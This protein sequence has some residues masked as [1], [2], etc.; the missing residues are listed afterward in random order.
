MAGSES[1]GSTMKYLALAL[2]LAACGGA[3]DD[4]TGDDAPGSDTVAPT[5]GT[6]ITITAPAESTRVIEWGAATDDVTAPALLQYKVVRG[7]D[8]VDLD[9]LELADAATTLQD[10]RSAT[11]TLE[12]DDLGVP[13]SFAVAVIVRDQTGNEALYAA[14]DVAVTDITPPD[15]TITAA[16]ADPTTDSTG[17]FEFSSDDPTATFQCSVDG[18]SFD[19]CASPFSTATLS[20]GPHTFAV[21]AV[22]A[23]SNA[24]P[25]PATA[26]WTFDPAFLSFPVGPTDVLETSEDGGSATFPLAL[27]AK[28]DSDVTVTLTTTD[29]TEGVV[30]T[31]AQLVFTPS[32][33]D[34]P[35]AVV[36]TGLADAD[37][38]DVTYQLQFTVESADVGYD[39]LQVTPIQLVNRD[40]STPPVVHF[41][42][43]VPSGTFFTNAS[44]VDI[45]GTASDA[46]GV[47]SVTWTNTVAAASGTATGTTTWSQ[48]AV[49]LV[50]GGN[51]IIATATDA[52][53]NQAIALVVVTRD[54]TPP[55][56]TITVPTTS[57]SITVDTPTIELGGNAADNV[58]VAS[59]TWKNLGTGATGTA[60]GTT[61]WS[62]LA[63]PVAIGGQ[64]IRVTATDTAGNT[65][66]TQ[67]QVVRN[68]HAPV[69]AI[70]SPSD[71]GSFLTTATS[72]DLAGTASSDATILSVSWL[73]ADTG[74]GATASG[75]AAWTAPGVPLVVGTNHVQVTVN[76]SLGLSTT[77]TLVV[78]RDGTGPAVKFTS[79]AGPSVTATDATIALAGTA[80]DGD[81]VAAVVF[82][83]LTNNTSGSATGTTAWTIPSVS[84][85][86]GPNTIVVTAVDS[87][88]NPGSATLAVLRPNGATAISAGLQTSCAILIG[89][90]LKC[91]GNNTSGQLGLGDSA[92]RGDAFKSMENLRPVDLGVGRTAL[93]VSVGISHVCAVLDDH[94]VKCWGD[95]SS[96]ALGQDGTT[97]IGRHAANEVAATP[98]VNLGTGRTALAV[99]TGFD[100]SCAL[101]DNHTVKCWG[102]NAN[103][104]L[105][106]GNTANVGEKTGQ[107]AKLAAVNLGTGRTALAIAVGQAHACAL[108][109]DHTVKCW[110]SGGF[111]ALGQGN[112]NDVGKAAGDMAALAPIDLGGGHTA[113]AIGAGDDHTCALLDNHALKCWGL[114]LDGALGQAATD[115]FVG[116]EPGEVAALP[117]ID[118]GAGRS[119]AALGSGQIH[120]CAILDDATLR[121][122]GRGDQ[123]QLGQGNTSNITSPAGTP[124]VSLGTGRHAVSVAAG[125]PFTCALL[126]NA[127]VKC[128]GNGNVGELGQNNKLQLGDQPG[129]MGD[130]LAAVFL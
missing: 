130:A 120:S 17:D 39:G 35:Q 1:F 65:A 96:G 62:E 22:D 33:F 93:S 129:E 98:A 78:T 125:N 48:T 9:T 99:G 66:T 83:N 102:L 37:T 7:V 5:P 18:G 14:V 10:F 26:S 69:I 27:G 111:G 127:S 19:P 40:D 87:L 101:L 61:A 108:L 46:G 74:D 76:D 117:A 95:N 57:T 97:D 56:V 121:C 43:P 59:V 52:A 68:A 44:T 105:G 128:W 6:D 64:T 42:T 94:S 112:A 15:T 122:W 67:L 80:T 58:E 24:D 109:D 82:Q 30:T 116:D 49:P 75:T 103:G 79:P 71:T 28:P 34:Q 12:L 32:N 89:G 29:D 51:P 21:R 38:A 118:F 20:S 84:L 81:G 115:G 91:W 25:T 47:A 90:D 54:I 88:G 63:V 124:A 123:G 23:A 126:D 70:T 2:L 45:T 31:G 11:T 13:D 41:A 4:T 53:G 119:V 50:V 3:A 60:L 107:M 36:I 114:D 86:P 8:T 16:E 100:F 73:N 104:Q 113:L 55:T 85:A 106:Q 110:G 77:A 72:V 92:T